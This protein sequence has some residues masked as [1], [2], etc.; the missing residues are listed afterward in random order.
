MNKSQLQE[1]AISLSARDR[2]A[3]AFFLWESLKAEEQAAIARERLQD[4]RHE[5]QVGTEALDRGDSSVYTTATL[6][7]LATDV[8]LRGR[9]RRAASTS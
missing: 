6:D 1:E 5:V 7:Q 4:L 3:L 2:A 9:E 8:K